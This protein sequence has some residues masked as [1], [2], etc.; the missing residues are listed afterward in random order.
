MDLQPLP[1]SQKKQSM[2]GVNLS[3]SMVASFVWWVCHLVCLLGLSVFFVGV[4]GNAPHGNQYRKQRV[5]V[6]SKPRVA[7][8]VS[9]CLVVTGLCK[10][11]TLH[12]RN[13]R[14]L[15]DLKGP[16]ILLVLNDTGPE[17]TIQP[18]QKGTKIQRRIAKE[19]SP[20]PGDDQE[21]RGMKDPPDHQAR[22]PTHPW[23]KT[24]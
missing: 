3:F 8:F 12:T 19:K 17:K 16:V 24:D 15:L 5:D 6:I 22:R 11:F 23:C 18:R 7:Q 9:L 21:K 4:T 1:S 10:E 13:P 14:E 20:K 2:S